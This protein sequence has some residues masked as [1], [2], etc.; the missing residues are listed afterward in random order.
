MP[1]AWRRHLHIESLC[2]SLVYVGATGYQ[3]LFS[4]NTAVTLWY[5]FT[6]FLSTL[7]FLTLKKRLIQKKIHWPK[8]ILLIKNTQFWLD[9]AE[10]LAFLH[11]HGLT[12]LTKFGEDWTKIVDFLLEAYFWVSVIFSKSVSMLPFHSYK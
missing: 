3:G 1:I 2:L 10:I 7:I 4:Y 6:Y 8:N 5:I 9:F 12:I 11:T